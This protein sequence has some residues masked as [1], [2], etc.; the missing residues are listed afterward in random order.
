MFAGHLPAEAGPLLC[1]GKVT[2]VNIISIGIIWPSGVGLCVYFNG[3][4][5]VQCKNCHNPVLV[6]RLSVPASVWASENHARDVLR[7]HTHNV[8]AAAFKGCFGELR[9]QEVRTGGWSGE[10]AARQ[11]TREEMENIKCLPV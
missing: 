8:E 5:Y 4:K 7:Q 10:K 1:Q 3:Q 2:F 6:V 9:Q 11:G